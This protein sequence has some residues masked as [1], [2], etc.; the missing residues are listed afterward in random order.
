MYQ[1]YG[2]F[3]I[4]KVKG[5]KAEVILKY[6]TVGLVSRNAGDVLYFVAR[7]GYEAAVGARRS[8]LNTYWL[9]TNSS[10]IGFYNLI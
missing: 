7:K 2:G 1:H 3:P 10:K 9:I 4:P 5:V 8:E 6:G